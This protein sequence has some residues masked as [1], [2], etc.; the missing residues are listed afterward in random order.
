M[1]WVCEIKLSDCTPA[2]ML[3]LQ[4]VV[5]A[6]F[7]DRARTRTVERWLWEAER[8]PLPPPLL[9]HRVVA[10]PRSLRRGRGSRAEQ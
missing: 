2:D 1:D 10:P 7:G 5:K 8:K 6:R 3:E 9:A 4:A